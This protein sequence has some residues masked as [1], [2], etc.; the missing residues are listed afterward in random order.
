MSV[1][2]TETISLFEMS[3]KHIESVTLNQAAK[4]RNKNRGPQIPKEAEIMQASN[5]IL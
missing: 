3:M 5:C 4:D 2:Q 1:L